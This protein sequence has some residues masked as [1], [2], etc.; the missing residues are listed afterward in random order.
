[1]GSGTNKVSIVKIN[2]GSFKVISTVGENNL[3]GE[4]FDTKLLNFLCKDFV[5]KWKKNV[6]NNPRAMR[7]LRV[8][9]VRARE[10]LSESREAIIDVDSL[11][12]DI[13]LHTK[14][15]R[16]QFENICADLFKTVLQ[17]VERALLD[18]GIDK[19]AIDEVVLIGG[20]TRIPK[21]KLM[22][23]DYFGE[24]LNMS[25][26]PHEMIARGAAVQAAILSEEGKLSAILQGLSLQEITPRSFGLELPE[27]LDI[28]IKKNT[29]IPCKK[30]RERYTIKKNQTGISLRVFGNDDLIGTFKLSGIEP[31]PA[32][33]IDVTFSLDVDGILQV[34]GRARK[35]GKVLDIKTTNDK[36]H[37]S[38]EQINYM[39][40]EAK[41]YRAYESKQK[42]KNRAR[43]DLESYVLSMKQSAADDHSQVPEDYRNEITGIC[44]QIEEWLKYYQHAET[45]EYENILEVIQ[46]LFPLI[47]TRMK[48]ADKIKIKLK[49]YICSM[50][51]NV[52]DD[53]KLTEVKKKQIIEVC[54]DTEGW[55]ENNPRAEKKD[56]MKILEKVEEK[57][58]VI[59]SQSEESSIKSMC[60][61]S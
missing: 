61:V 59:L 13:D 27:G 5:K 16:I 31:G 9:A 48:R 42:N 30:S 23:Q 52:Q 4:Y 50:K 14:I 1:M 54:D 10:C 17:P 37:R 55:L 6:Q 46:Q 12:D 24:K 19:M 3:G 36:G 40:S 57:C 43:R 35:S 56:Y 22:L 38:L 15:S 60:C 8:A 26:N 49:N 34:T 7:R 47:M 53:C 41:K 2:N 33:V 20:S 32:E 44:E 25:R 39:I 29:G 18:A 45:D 58:S 28:L 51:E 21:V 11:L